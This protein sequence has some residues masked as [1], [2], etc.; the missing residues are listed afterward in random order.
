MADQ[1]SKSL[2]SLML[3]SLGTLSDD[4]SDFDDIAQPVKELPPVPP[5]VA[6]SVDSYVSAS[7]AP[8]PLDKRASLQTLM[9]DSL[10]TLSEDDSDFD[11][12]A[13]PANA[14]PPAPPP[15]AVG[16]SS[17]APTPLD[18][19]AS[20]QT[21]MMDSLGTLSEDDSDFDDI[22][23]PA[24]ALPPAP[25]PPAVG[26]SSSAPAPFEHK[27]ASLQT[28]MMDSLGTLSEDDSDFD[29]I[30]QP[31]PV[32]ALSPAPPP[33][34]P[35]PLDKRTS[36]QTLMMDSLGTLSDDDSDFDDIVQPAKALPP[37]PP[38]AASYAPEQ[39]RASLQSLA[40]STVNSSS[41]SFDFDCTSPPSPQ[42]R[43][44]LMVS[45]SLDQDRTPLRSPLE[46]SSRGENKKMFFSK[47][48]Q[49]RSVL[50]MSS[51]GEMKNS[52][53]A[54]SLDSKG[55]GS[56]SDIDE[57]GD[58]VV[59]WMEEANDD[60][61][62]AL[63][64]ETA[65]PAPV[66]VEDNEDGLTAGELQLRSELRKV[67]DLRFDTLPHG[68]QLEII[69]SVE[70]QVFAPGEDIVI[71]GDEASGENG[72][73]YVILGPATAEVE[74]V[75]KNKGL[76]THLKQGK[77]FGEKFFIS[78]REATRT[79]T[80]TAVTETK[81]GL[82]SPVHFQKWD[83]FRLFL[84]MRTF[85]LIKTLPK[86]D[87]FEMYNLF[88]HE[89]FSPG[90][91]IVRQGDFGDK[92][93]IIV[94]G[95]A[96]V[97][98]LDPEFEEDF[99]KSISLTRLY[100]GH[101]FG[102]MALIFDEPRT[103][104]VV[105]VDRVSC[106]VLSKAAFREALSSA[107]H[108]HETMQ[109]LIYEI[110]S[111]REKRAAARA[112]HMFASQNVRGVVDTAELE[113]ALVGSG[114]FG[115]TKFSD[116]VEKTKI[117]SGPGRQKELKIN[118]YKTLG[119][120]GK[121]SFGSVYL[122]QNDETGKMFAMKTLL[123]QNNK[124]N[125]LKKNNEIRAEIDAMKGLRHDHIVAL[126]EV[127]DDPSSREVYLIQ[128]LLEGGP[129]LPNEAKTT[130]LPTAQARLYFRDMLRGVRYLHSKNIV[131]RDLKPQNMLRTDKDRVKIA[132]FGAAVFTGTQAA[133]GSR[134]VLT[135]GGTPAFMAPEIYKI[136]RGDGGDDDERRAYSTVYST[137]VDVWGLG[138]TLY[139]MVVGQ[140]PWMADNELELAET[141]RNMELTYPDN[142]QYI[143]PYLK[144]L[145]SRL[146]DKNPETRLS[147]DMVYTHDWVTSESSEPLDE[148][149]VSSDMSS[150]TA[151]IMG[152]GTS[153]Q[154]SGSQASLLSKSSVSSFHHGRPRHHGTPSHEFYGGI[155]S[156]P[157]DMASSTYS[158]GLSIPRNSS[159]ARKLSNNPKKQMY[160]SVM[161]LADN[162]ADTGMGSSSSVSSCDNAPA[163]PINPGRRN[164]HHPPSP[165][166]LEGSRLEGSRLCAAGSP[167]LD[168]STHSARHLAQAV[169]S[170]STGTNG[171]PES[172]ERIQMHMP[173]DFDE[174]KSL[175]STKMIRMT[176]SNVITHTGELRKALKI[177]SPAV[178]EDG[179]KEDYYDDYDSFDDFSDDEDFFERR[180]SPP[181]V[182]VDPVFP[183]SMNPLEV[184]ILIDYARLC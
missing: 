45:S 59:D 49:S 133:E 92:F 184:L 64:A 169:S 137:K 96:D 144:N 172:D 30:A 174:K 180:D 90:V 89:E 136:T 36:L 61:E 39:K 78:R 181:P 25:P 176:S 175:K 100:E 26:L 50:N 161:I 164:T 6:A 80:I 23:Q 70:V 71:E 31:Q 163:S 182:L 1:Q 19:R 103:A 108:F 151:S 85:P 55:V 8:A 83:N 42:T 52:A 18:K 158:I 93:Y 138:A 171:T 84:L 57:T 29:D 152:A 113:A 67:E 173:K 32:K 117:V 102:E 33:A 47:L 116:V 81:V 43:P 149:P 155:D 16:L 35:A 114:A 65:A 3:G 94:E 129:I 66:P 178:Q 53:S 17:S 107:K 46:P 162:S 38:S 48:Q 135:A 28:L 44:K 63:S 145:L 101:S 79:A 143:D 97:K 86:S 40:L 140:P 179:R 77:C 141:V 34:L 56:M 112:A 22:A 60:E 153:R 183:S 126:E 21:L 122:V 99:N 127:I 68:D 76:M 130:P 62:S 150:R 5:P 115:T 120:L 91:F 110:L 111:R 82:V 132:D 157:S 12:I 95:S 15:P 142:T 123:R 168:D 37:P 146:L 165:S 9:M 119:V 128:E 147:M 10:G 75:K 177:I 148:S 2:H 7:A 4:D 160:E 170:M 106:F 20:L 11:D 104:S 54:D 58:D 109:D 134:E 167:L 73:F 74:I 139:N 118:K 24:N 156:M 98:E 124:W 72:A 27:R 121:G 166:G 14:L 51:V 41:D 87:Q 105:A 88:T 13:Q 154:S 131:H 69:R 159:H 125:N